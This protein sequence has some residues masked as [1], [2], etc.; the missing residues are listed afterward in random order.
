MRRVWGHYVAISWLF[1]GVI[2]ALLIA[3]GCHVAFYYLSSGPSAS[4]FGIVVFATILSFGV[5]VLMHSGGLYDGEA[6]FDLRRV[7][8]RIGVLTAPV[9]LLAVVTTGELAR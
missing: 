2:E 8:W 6:V 3:A 5:I 9:F 1:L 4:P 7:L